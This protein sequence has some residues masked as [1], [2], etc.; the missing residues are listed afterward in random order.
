MEELR[1][2]RAME[3]NIFALEERLM[4]R[5]DAALAAFEDEMSV[6]LDHIR[7]WQSSQLDRLQAQVAAISTRL[8][9]MHALHHVKV[10]EPAGWAN[11]SANKRALSLLPTTPPSEPSTRPWPRTAAGRPT[12]ITN[13]DGRPETASGAPQH[14]DMNGSV[15]EEESMIALD[16]SVWDASLL[17][18]SNEDSIRQSRLSLLFSLL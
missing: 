16:N 17:M 8:D 15:A 2:L 11:G 4:G 18:G 1:A 14:P 6:Q 5:Q 7:L 10:G 3:G 9:E 13:G 12:P